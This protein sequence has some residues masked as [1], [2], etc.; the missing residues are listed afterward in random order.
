VPLASLHCFNILTCPSLHSQLVG[1][2]L[3]RMVHRHPDLCL[4][5]CPKGCEYPSP[6]SCV[7]TLFLCAL[8]EVSDPR[9]LARLAV[10][11]CSSFCALQR[12]SAPHSHALLGCPDPSLSFSDSECPSLALFWCPDLSLCHPSSGGECPSFP[13]PSFVVLT[14]RPL[15][16]L[17]LVSALRSVALFCYPDLYFPLCS[18]VCM[19]P[20][21]LC[22]VSLS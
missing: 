3:A 7:L 11:N 21:L 6:A 15:C 17:Q 22:F 20:L 12:V 5:L 2:S 9:S 8:Q 10:L 4:C 13:R 1:G 19:S 18:P 16:V 14:C